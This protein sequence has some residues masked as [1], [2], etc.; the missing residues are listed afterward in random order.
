IGEIV[1]GFDKN[2]AHAVIPSRA[3]AIRYAVEN[4]GD[5]DVIL[6][7]GKGH[8][9]YEL[10]ARGKRDF[11]ESAIVGESVKSRIIRESGETKEQNENE[12]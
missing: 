11:D 9:K 3:D 12:G 10:G 8:E 6:L 1:G 5:G 7:C 4:A 2:K